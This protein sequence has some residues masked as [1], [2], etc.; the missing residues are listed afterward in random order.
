MRG[1]E[2]TFDPQLTKPQDTPLHA[3]H[4]FVD[5]SNILLRRSLEVIWVLKIVVMNHCF[6]LR[7]IPF[8]LGQKNCDSRLLFFSTHIT[9]K[10]RRRWRLRTSTKL[11]IACK[12]VSWGLQVE[13]TKPYVTHP[14][15]TRA[16]ICHAGR[17]KKR[18]T[19]S[20]AWERLW[21]FSLYYKC[22]SLSGL[23]RNINKMRQLSLLLLK[24][25]PFESVLSHFLQGWGRYLY[26]RYTKGLHLVNL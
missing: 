9:S 21:R 1:E 10:L 13:L 22:W 24:I 2:D 7:L 11:R 23:K 6:W 25:G 16:R 3:T 17:I 12:G 14:R 20:A 8:Y 4:N 5:V 15:S 26:R 18:D 19:G